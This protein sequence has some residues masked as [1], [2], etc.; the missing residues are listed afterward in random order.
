MAYGLD[1]LTTNTSTSLTITV[2]FDNAASSIQ[3]AVIDNTSI[4]WAS[5]HE[6]DIYSEQLRGKNDFYIEFVWGNGAIFRTEKEPITKHFNINRLKFNLASA[7]PAKADSAE[8]F[9]GAIQMPLL[10]DVLDSIR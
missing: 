8:A 6:I 3:L 5:K 9:L 1:K 4:R 10:I 7:L 2:Y